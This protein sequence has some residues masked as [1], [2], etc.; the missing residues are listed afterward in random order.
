M[1]RGKEE[2]ASPDLYE[3]ESLKAEP[4]TYIQALFWIKK[5]RNNI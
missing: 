4:L 5:L 3:G 1:K 2:Q